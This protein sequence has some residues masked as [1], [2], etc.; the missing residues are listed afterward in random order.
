MVIGAQLGLLLVALVELLALELL[1]SLLLLVAPGPLTQTHIQLFV[2]VAGDRVG[3]LRVLRLDGRTGHIDILELAAILRALGFRLL[4]DL[5]VLIYRPQIIG[6][7][8]LI[9]EA[10]ICQKT[11]RGHRLSIF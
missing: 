10:R 2:E 8:Y 4:N 5:I 11:L 6:R 9:A 3:V 7:N 1:L